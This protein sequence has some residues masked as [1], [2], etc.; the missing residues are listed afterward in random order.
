M[1]NIFL[2]SISNTLFGTLSEA[3]T[4]RFGHGQLRVVGDDLAEL[5][6]EQV[7]FRRGIVLVQKYGRPYLPDVRQLT[8]RHRFSRFPDTCW[9]RTDVILDFWWRRIKFDRWITFLLQV[10]RCKDFG[11]EQTVLLTVQNIDIFFI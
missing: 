11:N 8:T 3:L 6:D 2:W 9:T 5:H 4:Q 1:N 7:V 10:N